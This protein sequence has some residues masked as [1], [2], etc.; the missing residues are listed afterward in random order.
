M[1][2][3]SDYFVELMGSAELV[4]VELAPLV[5]TQSSGTVGLE[6]MAKRL[7]RF[8]VSEFLIEKME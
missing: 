1:D 3:L 8:L 7:D 4:D 6:W 5:S 2:P